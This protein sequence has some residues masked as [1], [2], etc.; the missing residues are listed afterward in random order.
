M[1]LQVAV[2]LERS[3]TR[4]VLVVVPTGKNE[5]LANPE[6][7]TGGPEMEQLSRAIGSGYVLV[8]PHNPGSFSYTAFGGQ[9][10]L[11]GWMSLTV[12]VKLQVAV[13]PLASVARKVLTVAPT[14][15]N[16][17]LARPVVRVNEEMPQLSVADVAA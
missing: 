14:G 17:P 12:T 3:A 10:R 4:Q 9:V 2:V 16:E 5:P 7:N 13:K 1:K 8:A 11:G 6:I 15:K